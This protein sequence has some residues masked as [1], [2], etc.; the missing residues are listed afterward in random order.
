[1][2]RGGGGLFSLDANA[3]GGQAGMNP[4]QL[5]ERRLDGQLLLFQHA[6]LLEALL[7]G[8]PQAVGLRRLVPGEHG[9]DLREGESELLSSQDR[10][11]PG[12]ILRPV[13]AHGPLPPRRDES[14]VF[15]KAKRPQGHAEF[16][17]QLA[18]RQFSLIGTCASLVATGRRVLDPEHVAVG[19]CT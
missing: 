14:L 4:P 7:R 8:E 9:P 19:I 13:E 15:V 3:I 16:A 1:W 10:R 18:N 2:W 11:K 17:C 5:R 6:D 12:A